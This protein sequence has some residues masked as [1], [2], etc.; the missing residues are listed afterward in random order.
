[1]D[2]IELDIAGSALLRGDEVL[3]LRPKTLAVLVA[4]IE[5]Q[6]D[7]VSQDELH[8]LVWGKRHGSDAG[9][10][11][12]IRELRRLL[13]DD[14]SAPTFIETVGRS[15]Y[16]L[17][18]RINPRWSPEPRPAAPL[19]VGRASALAALA[20]SAAAARQ[21]RHAVALIAGE[22]GAG[23][24]RLVDGFL[25]RFPTRP[26]VWIARG[27]AISHPGAREPYG[28]LLEALSQLLAG[29]TGAQLC[30][31][32]PEVAPT[33]AEQLPGAGR[34]Q[35]VAAI[36]VDPRRPAPMPREFSA[37]MERLTQ[38]APGILVLED[39]HWA[40]AS[41]LAW[42]S[43]W[44]LRRTPARLLVLGTY[45]QDEL[46]RA[47]DLAATLRHL[48]RQADS[49]MLT[50]DGLDAAAVADYLAG[51]FP[52]HRFPP[53]L[54]PALTRRTEGHAILIEA[55]VDRWLTQGDIRQQ[56]GHWALIGA[57]DTLVPA[58]APDMQ[59]FIEGDRVGRLDPPERALLEAASV[60]GPGFSALALAD[61]RDGRETVERQLEHLARNRRFIERAGLAHHP[62]GSVTTRYAFRHALH[63]EA[64]YAGIPAANRQG[65]HRR[66]GTRLEALYRGDAAEIAP[67]L[68][69]HFER[70]ADWP[71]A[72]RYRGLSGLRAQARGAQQAAANQLRQALELHARCPDPDV[73]LQADELRALLGLGAALIVSEGFTADELRSVYRRAG[74]LAA[75]VGE[76][77]TT[78]PV[79]AGLWNDHVSRAELDRATELAQTL[80]QMAKTAP[81]PIAMAAQNAVGQ[82]RFFTGAFADCLP[83][84]DTVLTLHPGRAPDGVATLFGEEPGI[85]CRQYAACVSQVLGCDAEAEAH[86]AA[87][88]DLA[89]ALDQPFGQAQMLWAG[90][91]VAR[92]RGDLALTRARAEALIAL[93]QSADIPYW[94][95]AGT[96]LAGW[97]RAMDGD[98]DGQALLDQGLSAYAAMNV[99]LTLPLGLALSAEVAARRGDAARGL[100]F[101]RRALATVRTTGERWYEAE[102]HRLWA[103]MMGRAG[104][105]D[106]ARRALDRARDIAR[107]QGA[108]AFEAR[109]AR[110][111]AALS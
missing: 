62:D 7:I 85:V 1:M 4:L 99:R 74:P 81:A 106:H 50:L 46:D 57:V 73:S 33:W 9:P 6:G 19:C 87:G 83:C 20:E 110:A 27:Q 32:L 84:I 82:T 96:M 102:L 31:L 23:K 35:D 64:L 25:A 103:L 15:G 13:G 24:T 95:P 109:A 42:L 78:V 72:A 56:D 18:G 65:L 12:C 11:Q 14:A 101:L 21:G 59:A 45:R 63:H 79:L 22:A 8:R 68:A 2:P 88:T 93:C 28:P 91:V 54:A 111:I 69:D 92:L 39:L 29:P 17:T 48:N 104:R 36:E 3:K 44:G 40:D 52:G 98:P 38:M 43:A 89:G 37:L 41:T 70:G 71:R 77:A 80:H 108:A 60:A 100:P 10:K 34:H 86:V 30:R 76:P 58:I 94:L 26:A 61:G 55:A 16:R 107:R 51:R 105:P 49:R 66:I 67:A 97:A 90:A 47:D 75:R 5:R 53:A